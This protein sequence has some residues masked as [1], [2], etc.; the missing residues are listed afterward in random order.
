MLYGINGAGATITGDHPIKT[1]D[2]WKA[3]TQEAADLYAGKEGFAKTPLK[4]GDTI[5]TETGTVK[6]TDIHRF[7]M[8]QAV[9]TYNLRVKGDDSF[10]ANGMAV[11]GFQ[12]MERQYQ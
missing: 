8:L 10:Y 1:T 9:T 4:V 11:K 6:V 2:G 7:P 3:I 5:V 12:K